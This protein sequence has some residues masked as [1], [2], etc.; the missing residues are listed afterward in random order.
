M[1]ALSDLQPL[2]APRSIAVVGASENPGPGLQALENL[3]RLGFAG[4]VYPVNPRYPSVLGMACYPSLAAVR[5]AGHEVDLVAILLNRGQVLGVLEQAGRIGARAAWAFA[6][7]FAEAGPEG[8]KLQEE[9][10]GICR[11]YSIRFCGPNCVGILNFNARAGAYS[12][13]APREILPGGIGVVAQSG[14]ICIQVANANRG[15]GYSLILSAGNEAVVDATDYLEYLVEDPGTRVIAAFI[16]QFRRPERLPEIARRAR[17]AGKPVLLIKVG[18]SEMARRASAAHTG[19]LAGADDVQDAL[20]RKLGLIRVNDLDEMFEAAELFDKLG[21]RLP[22]GDGIFATTLS[23][24][25]ISLLGDLG[26]PLALRFPAWSEEGKRRV[27]ELLPPYASIDN[28][29]DAWGFGR[30]EETYGAFLQAAVE[31]PAADL[32]LV[33]Q[34]VPGGMAPRQVAQYAAVARAAAEISGRTDKPVVFLSNPSTGFDPEIR[35]TLAEAGVPLLQ[36]TREGLQAVRHLIDRARFLRNPEEASAAA[37]PSLAASLQ[38]LLEGPARGLT[39]Y[40]SKRVLAGYG[41]PCTPE[42]LCASAQEAIAAARGL[43]GRVALKVMSPE[44]LHKTEAGVIALNVAGDKAVR[45][46]YE[47]LAA[48]AA[49]FRPEAPRQGVLCQKMVEGAVAEVIVGILNDPQWG[50]AVVFGTG[51]VLVEVLGDRSL[52][53]PPLDPAAARAMI[54]QTRGSRLL[55]GFRGRPRA[56]IEALVRLIVSVGELAVEQRGRIEALDLNPVLVM[57]EGQGVVAVDA[58]LYTRGSDSDTGGTLP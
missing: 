54:L 33:S 8:R 55:E 23:G 43:G 42:K 7:G 48:A 15:L 56:D 51:G 31:E 27:R 34:D 12:A 53:I 13:P 37:V 21:R 41:I 11:R 57:P 32:L 45:A 29:L 26:E 39:E 50:P 38:A 1:A 9:L 2:I 30:V 19:A 40:D 20:F 24:G 25:V 3:R 17:A 46:A 14:Y 36:G 49:R 52:A 22:A 44:I 5:E 47:R 6:N 18:R 28:P 35:R 58:L 4:P 16:E 10:A